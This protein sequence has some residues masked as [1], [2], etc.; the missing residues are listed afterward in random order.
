[1]GEPHLPRAASNQVTELLRKWS[2]GDQAALDALLPLVY[3]ELRRVAHHYRQRERPDHTLQGTA[4]VHEGYLR[5]VD[6][7]A[8]FQNR[9]HQ[10]LLGHDSFEE[11]GA[12]LL[13][14][15]A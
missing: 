10:G 4:V 1:M 9:Q 2:D 12:T 6:A 8:Q 5:L 13:E 15:K 14:N 3:N 7:P 11:T